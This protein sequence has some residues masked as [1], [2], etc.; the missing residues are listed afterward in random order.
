MN[1]GRKIL[2]VTL[3][4]LNLVSVVSLLASYV[5][6]FINPGKAWIFAFFGLAYPVILLIN[7]IF[8]FIWLIL[9]KRYI[10]ISLICI[11]L[12]WNNLRSLYPFRFYASS[13]SNGISLKVLSYNVHRLYGQN[14]STRSG[15]TRSK[16]TDF[17]AGQKADIMFIQEFFARGEDY[18]VT[19]E[20]FTKS[21]NL[22]YYSFTNYR[23]FQYKQ[24]INAIA[25]F[26]KY[27]IVNSGHFKLQDGSLFAVFADIVIN[28][29]TIRLYN[30][31]LESIRFGNEDY[32]FYSH[33]TEPDNENEA[34]QLKEGSKRM[35]WKLRKAFILR[36]A[37]VTILSDDVAMCRYPVILGGDF[38][39]TPSSYTYYQLTQTLND[40]FKESGNGFFESTYLGKFPSFR[41]DY[42][43]YS[44]HFKSVE[45]KKIDIS[46][47]D[48]YPIVST[49]IYKAK[50]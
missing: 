8:V 5:A 3:L 38:N 26:S 43:M 20:K 27:P 7:I 40:S 6:A 12:G 41:I 36:A 47:S 42:I 10:F 9:W 34:I 39:D 19:L 23:S 45:Y 18:L 14:R 17:L 28:E 21:I 24:K 50:K 33:L 30:L 1:K 37:Q 2:T 46:L 29:D 16:V 15:E 31:H 4:V 13:P 32:S 22:E 35:L 11:L 49:L 44:S 48:H 25:I